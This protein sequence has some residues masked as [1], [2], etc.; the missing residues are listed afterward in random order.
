MDKTKLFWIAVDGSIFTE[1][2]FEFKGNTGVKYKSRLTVALNVGD[3]VANRIV[4][5]HN[6]NIRP[7]GDNQ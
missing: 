5:L 7:N 2:E 4:H 3:E 6:K 1:K